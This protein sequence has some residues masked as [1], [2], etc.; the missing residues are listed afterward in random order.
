MMSCEGQRTL[1]LQ[2]PNIGAEIITNTIL[3]VPYYSYSIKGPK[4]LF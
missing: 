3:S 4:T 1:G 2:L